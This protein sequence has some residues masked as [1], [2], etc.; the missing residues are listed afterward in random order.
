M[1]DNY[2]NAFTPPRR[3]RNDHIRIHI[4][5]PLA[6]RIEQLQRRALLLTRPVIGVVLAEDPRDDGIQLLTSQIHPR[7]CR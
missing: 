3:K 1:P 5:V 4:D 6:L 2:L 7:S